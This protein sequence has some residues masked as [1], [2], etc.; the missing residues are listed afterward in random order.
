MPLAAPLVAD[1][2]AEYPGHLA[3]HRLAGRL[4]R[5]RGDLATAEQHFAQIEERDCDPGTRMSLRE[6]RELLAQVTHEH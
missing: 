3:G 1:I 4:A 2:L 5:R 6:I